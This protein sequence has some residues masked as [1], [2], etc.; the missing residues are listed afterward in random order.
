M[1][2]QWLGQYSGDDGGGIVVLDIDDSEDC[3]EGTAYVYPDNKQ[4]PGTYGYIKTINKD[5]PCEL[6][7]SIFPINRANNNIVQW[8]EISTN[9]P[10]VTHGQKAK[11]KIEL[12]EEILSVKWETDIGVKGEAKLP[13][14]RA[15]QPTEYEPLAEVNNWKEFKEFVCKLEHRRYIFRGQRQA[16][17]L[18]TTFHRTGRADLINFLNNDIVT[19]HRHLSQRTKHIF[20]LNV[21]DQNGAFFNLVQHHGYPTPL[22]DWTYSPFVSAFFA[23]RKI[24]EADVRKTS[25]NEKVRIFIFDQKVWRELFPQMKL[26]TG[27][28]HFSITEFIAIENERMVPQ[29]SISS[30]TN[31]DDIESYIRRME[32]SFNKQFLKIIDLPIHERSQI[33][34]ELSTMGITAGSLFPGLDG[35]CE[36]LRERFFTI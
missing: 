6:N 9:Y 3:F 5:L 19:L 4:L 36:E 18:R 26:L 10:G 12:N 31:I 22:L 23:F 13:R 11:V 29:Q 24:R 16:K 15:D 34:K 27:Q 30:V 28:P 32:T 8:N 17:R 21:P 7:T 35:A 1:N 33:M 25:Q 14:S 20:D 2:G